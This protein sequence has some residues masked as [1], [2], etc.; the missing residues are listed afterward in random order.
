MVP[1]ILPLHPWMVEAAIAQPRLA[2]RSKVFIT[3]NS[4]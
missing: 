1:R 4:L 3:I 2:T